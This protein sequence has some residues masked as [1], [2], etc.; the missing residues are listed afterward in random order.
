M[1]HHSHRLREWLPLL[2][3]LLLLAATYWLNQQVQPLPAKTVRSGLGEPD[4]VISNISATSINEHGTPRFILAARKVTHH[5]ADD[6]TLLDEPHLTS[7]YADRPPV[8]TS[9]K[10]GEISS[11]GDEIFL[12]GEVK[13]VRAG[14]ARQSE[15]SFAT[16]YLHVVPDL[17]LAD[18]DRPV[19][20]K[21]AHNVVHAVGMEID[22]KAR[23]VKLLSQVRSQHE[24]AKN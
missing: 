16:D 21:D 7:L 19:V 22:N 2:P 13:L 24:T 11:E 10:Q 14:G 3:L 15:Q 6:S 12:R 9:A 17:D 4:F 23:M 18:T 1:M 5:P 8:Y 20:L